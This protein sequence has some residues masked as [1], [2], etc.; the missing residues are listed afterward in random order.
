MPSR[1]YQLKLK[2]GEESAVSVLA[3]ETREE[4]LWVSSKALA[5]ESFPPCIRNILQIGT[6]NGRHRTAAILA[7]FLGQA[8]WSEAD[9]RNLWS[10]VI[11]TAVED[12]IF[13]EWF[14]KMHCPKCETLKR[15]S[16][17]YPDLGIADLNLCLPDERCKGFHGPVAYAAEIETENDMSRGSLS[18]IKTLHGAKIF[19]WSSGREEVI[20]LSDAEKEELEDLLK[21]QADERDKIVIY[22][23]T[24]VRGRLKPRFLLK[25][26]EG[27]RKKMMSDFIFK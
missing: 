2:E 12:R 23:R 5:V 1:K 14:G 27:L 21:Q 10:T 18:H 8:G 25:Q 19:D 3:I 13:A 22:T 17:G 4:M 6:D 15:R 26:A 11:G 24:R 16:K 20:E 9:A 7:A